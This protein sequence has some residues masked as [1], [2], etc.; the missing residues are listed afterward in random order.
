MSA[1][2]IKAL[3]PL[4][5][6]P[7]EGAWLPLPN[8]GAQAYYAF[9]LWLDAGPARPKVLSRLSILHHWEERALAYDDYQIEHPDLPEQTHEQRHKHNLR[10]IQ[11]LKHT[12]QSQ[13]IK[14]L[15]ALEQS[16][17]PAM[18]LEQIAKVTDLI[19]KLERLETNQSTA[20]ISVRGPNLANLSDEEIS[21]LDALTEKAEHEPNN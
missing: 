15:A 8:E 9:R 13:A 14:L 5:N 19:I 2:L 11:I 18:T 12:T 4:T 1:E 20:N 17:A 16:Q 7:T 10:T 6:L 21:Q 3:A